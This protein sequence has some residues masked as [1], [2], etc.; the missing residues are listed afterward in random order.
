MRVYGL[1]FAMT[2]FGWMIFNPIEFEEYGKE[3]WILLGIF[4]GVF[5]IGDELR[6]IKEKL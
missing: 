1:L 6:G 5:G 3:F 4:Y 2:Y